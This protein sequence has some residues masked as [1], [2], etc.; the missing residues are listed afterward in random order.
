MKPQPSPPPPH[1]HT[2][3]FVVYSYQQI[4]AAAETG[5]VVFIPI[6]LTKT[7]HGGTTEERKD[8]GVVAII[9]ITHHHMSERGGFVHT[10][11][12]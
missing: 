11:T 8:K 6:G 4:K 12:T 2:H 1:T 10:T 7:P 3:R 5:V 9:T